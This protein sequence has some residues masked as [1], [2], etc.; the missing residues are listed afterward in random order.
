MFLEMEPHNK[1]RFYRALHGLGQVEFG[2]LM[3]AERP[4]VAKWEKGA[5]LPK[6]EQM[7]KIDIYNWVRTGGRLGPQFFAPILPD[8]LMRPQTVNLF[9]ATISELM[10][11]F[12]RDEKI[13]RS[14]VQIFAF[15]DGNL[16][17]LGIHCIAAFGVF[18]QITDCLPD[19]IKPVHVSSLQTTADGPLISNIDTEERCRELLQLIGFPA[20]VSSEM[21]F[22]KIGDMLWYGLTIIDLKITAKR[23]HPSLRTEAEEV[24]EVAVRHA[25]EERFKS[26]TPVP[27]FELDFQ[28]IT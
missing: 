21:A 20:A 14:D 27:V 3:G 1:I 24:I 28:R 26:S 4:A 8:Q 25:L 23:L 17:R 10:A 5:Y 15:P 12:C 19:E 13:E 2:H 22:P 6:P 16:I 9:L 18:R 11:D 7:A